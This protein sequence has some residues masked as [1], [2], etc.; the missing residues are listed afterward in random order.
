MPKL[1]KLTINGFKSIKELTDFELRDINILIGSNG[2]GKSNFVEFFRMLKEIMQGNLKDFTTRNGGADDFLFNGPRITSQIHSEL[3]FGDNGYRFTLEPTADETFIFKT[4]ERYYSR[5]QTG[6]WVIGNGHTEARLP[7]EKGEAGVRSQ[8]GV[9]Y[10]V[11]NA[12]NS[13]QIYHFHDTSHTAAARRS[14]IVD[15]CS[16]LRSNGSNIAPYLFYLREEKND[17]YQRII[18]NVRLTAPFFDDFLLKPKKNGEKSEK[19][20]LDWKQKGSDYPMQP[21]HFSDGTLRFICLAT[22]L[23]MPVPPSVI[24]LDEPELGLHPFA[25]S[26]LAG[27]I[28]SASAH[29]QL[30]VSTQSTTLLN[31]FAPDDTVVVERKGGNESVF[32]RLENSQLEDWLEDYTLGELF[33][34]NVLD[35]GPANV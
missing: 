21:Y 29:S 13:W 30:I 9:A 23:S 31:H 32:T 26:V 1:D 12:I 25:I 33:E 14:E 27:L 28:Q 4:E 3:L 18:D 10:Y 20:K 2:A 11:Y 6:W 19:V 22:L 34:K 8:H 16:I 5:G 17:I 35:G 7:S 24:L 15:D